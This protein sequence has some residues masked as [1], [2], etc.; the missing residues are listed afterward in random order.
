MELEKQ[1]YIQYNS[2]NEEAKFFIRYFKEKHLLE[3]VLLKLKPFR[4]IIKAGELIRY[5]EFKT[6]TKT[7]YLVD[8]IPTIS[9]PFLFS[10]NQIQEYNKW[11]KIANNYKTMLFSYRYRKYL[12]EN[13]IHTL[14]TI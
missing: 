8:G 13:T 1:Q 11:V 12:I 2:F 5:L 6:Q 4:N 9:K 10:K 3:K 14:N 7:S